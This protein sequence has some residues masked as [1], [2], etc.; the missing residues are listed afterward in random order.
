MEIPPERR[1]LWL[2]LCYVKKGQWLRASVYCCLLPNSGCCLTSCLKHL[3][4]VPHH[5]RLHPQTVGQ[6]KPFFSSVVSVLSQQQE[7]QL[8]HSS[9]AWSTQGSQ[10][11]CEMKE[12]VNG[13]TRA[14]DKS[15][16]AFS[17]THSMHFFLFS[18]FPELG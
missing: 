1:G 7:K 8:K 9:V 16:S 13:A 12:L 14:G 15:V 3:P 6:S 10:C 18:F 5:D 2:V 11:I 4:C 17:P